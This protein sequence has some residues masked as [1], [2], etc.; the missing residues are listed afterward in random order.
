M[1]GESPLPPVVPDT[2]P[3]IATDAGELPASSELSRFRAAMAKGEVLDLPA[4]APEE[5]VPAP[6]TPAPVPVVAKVED[7]STAAPSKR[8]QYIND[9]IRAQTRAEVERER[10][11][12]DRDYL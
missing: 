2:G 8:K 1:A 3:P 11:E 7:E 4:P 9:L 6:A 10:A 12:A 5:P